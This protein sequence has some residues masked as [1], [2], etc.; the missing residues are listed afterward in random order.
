MSEALEGVILFNL[1]F[2]RFAPNFLWSVPIGLVAYMILMLLKHVL[3]DI[4]AFIKNMNTSRQEAL[5]FLYAI[6]LL[7]SLYLLLEITIAAYEPVVLYQSGGVLAALL[8]ITC[9]KNRS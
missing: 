5:G 1:T 2:P 9:M 8:L 6:L 7:F 4:W 3:K